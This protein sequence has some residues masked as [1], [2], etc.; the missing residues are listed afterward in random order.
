V[1][2]EILA[3][4]EL[5]KGAFSIVPCKS[6]DAAALI[7]DERSKLLSF[8]GSAEVGWALKRRAGK[9]RVALELGGNAACIVDQDAILDDAVER[10]VFGAFYQ[11]GQSCVSV[12]R[13]LAH[14]KIYDALREKLAAATRKLVGGDPKREDVFIGP[15]IT[16]EDAKRLESWIASATKR[17]ARVVCGGTRRGSI[18]DATL[19]ENVPANE[20][21]CN[22]EAFG[23]VAV[24]SRFEDFDDALDAVN[25]S[26][27]GLQAG[28]F[29]RDLHRAQRAWE[30]L[31]VGAV[32]VGDVPSWR[33]D[34][35]PYGGVK[36]S[37]QGREGVRFAIE[38]MS[39]V[40]L[41][42]VRTPN[43]A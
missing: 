2:G 14:A 32:I 11:S 25:D 34:A 6:S 10:I 7:E 36:D 17:G 42:V 24:L 15:L 20:P 19:V 9:K 21:L 33:A 31:E 3:E 43:G 18:L 4:T 22:E 29:T 8:T 30:R 28:V 40:R 13:I 41:L 37:G 12:Q 38:E 1:I 16:E 5:P 27:F 35:M 26:R 39:E 23:P